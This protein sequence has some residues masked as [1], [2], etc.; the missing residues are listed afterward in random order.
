[1]VPWQELFTDTIESPPDS[2]PDLPVSFSMSRVDLVPPYLACSLTCPY[3]SWAPVQN[4]ILHRE[5]P[6]VPHRRVRGEPED[7]SDENARQYKDGY[8]SSH[9]QLLSPT[10]RF[11]ISGIDY[12]SGFL[13]PLG[14]IPSHFDLFR[15]SVAKEHGPNGSG[16]SS[17]DT[18]QTGRLLS[19]RNNN[20]NKLFRR[21][22]SHLLRVMPEAETY[23]CGRFSIEVD[24]PLGIGTGHPWVFQLYPHPDPE[25]NS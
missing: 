8:S 9:F 12:A 7:S 25:N 3:P 14:P 18:T 4:P 21:P 23:S 2:S 1:M 17:S 6:S 16:G 19:N 11:Q 5:L 10:G 24:P 22:R 15:L 13:S 20:D